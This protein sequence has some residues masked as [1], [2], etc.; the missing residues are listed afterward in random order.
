MPSNIYGDTMNPIELYGVGTQ[1]STW[2]MSTAFDKGNIGTTLGGIG[3]GIGLI[4]GIY[5]ANQN[6]K[7]KNRLYDMEK[8]RVE[9][10]QAKEDRFH[11]DMSKAW[12]LKNGK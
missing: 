2:S 6:R 7:M 3:Q 4:S 1:P 8:K 12:G 10:N 11:N 5:S 9:R